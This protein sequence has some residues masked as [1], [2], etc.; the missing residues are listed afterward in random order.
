MRVNQKAH[1]RMASFDGHPGS[2]SRGACFGPRSS[3]PA[4]LDLDVVRFFFEK[5]HDGGG[6]SDHN[7]GEGYVCPLPVDDGDD[8]GGERRHGHA[9]KVVAG[10]DDARH[11]SH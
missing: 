8:G 3:C 10:Y 9:A 6:E 7:D 5:E 1:V 4:H 11:A 2:G